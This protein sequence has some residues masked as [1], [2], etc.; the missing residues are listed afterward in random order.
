MS[1]YS[2]KISWLRGNASLSST[3]AT[4][5]RICWQFDGG[6]E[7]PASS[8]PHVRARAHVGRGGGRSGGGLHRIPCEL[9]HALVSVARGGTTTSAS[10]VYVDAA[11]GVLARVPRAKSR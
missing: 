2:A 4:A 5:A 6:I 8:S 9:S 1:E 11:V 10:T 3:I 7:V